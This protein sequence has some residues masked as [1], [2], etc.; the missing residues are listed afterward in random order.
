MD[1]YSK[2]VLI[3]AGNTMNLLK[4]YMTKYGYK[5]QDE[6]IVCLDNDSSKWDNKIN[7]VLIRPIEEIH[8][9]SESQI[10]IASIY[11]KELREQLRVLG[12]EERRVISLNSYKRRLFAKYQKRI[13]EGRHTINTLQE[14]INKEIPQITVYTAIFGSYDNLLEPVLVNPNVRY[15]CFTDNENITSDIWEVH[16]VKRQYECPIIESRMYKILPH[17]F[18]E[19][20]YSIWVDA[21]IRLLVDPL[22]YVNCYLGNNDFLL[23]P[24]GERDCIYEEAAICITLH[25]ASTKDLVNQMK[26]YMDE[27]CPEHVGLFWGGM[28]VRRHHA[29]QIKNFDELWWKEFLT[30]SKRDQVSLGYLLWKKELPISLC[31]IDIYDNSIVKVVNHL[32]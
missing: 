23:V 31:D 7:G 30:Y 11:E 12:V 22:Q 25:R 1:G 28:L 20:E 17:L 16:C 24:H 5:F 14:S 3:G 10:V 9:Y 32:K 26:A 15:I 19:D 27:G 21:N 2:M 4:V 13:Y 18:I 29:A 8:K 6:F